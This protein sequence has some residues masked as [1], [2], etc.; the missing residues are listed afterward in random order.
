MHRLHELK[1]QIIIEAV[2]GSSRMYKYYC[3]NKHDTLITMMDE[4]YISWPTSNAITSTLILIPRQTS[5]NLEEGIWES[6]AL[7]R[8]RGL[9]TRRTSKLR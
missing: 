9:M 3:P 6:S 1:G 5:K 8:V 7:N 2:G 4:N